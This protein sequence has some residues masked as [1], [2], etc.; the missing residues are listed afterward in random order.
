[1]NVQGR[2]FFVR[3]S[4]FPRRP[5]IF[6]VMN[7]RRVSLE[8]GMSHGRFVWYDLSTPDPE[9][10]EA[11]YTN[12]I[13][14]GT[15]PIPGPDGPYTLFMV[16]ETPVCG[17]M[18][19]PEEAKKLSAPPHWMG[20]VVVDNVDA[21]TAAAQQLGATIYIE[22]R[23][24]TDICRFSVIADP[25][26]AAIGMMAWSA[27]PEAAGAGTGLPAVPGRIG[28]HELLTSD[29]EQGYCFYQTLFGWQKADALDA[30]DIGTYQVF[31][32]GGHLAGGMFNKPAEI[33]ATFWLYYFN[34]ADFDAAVDRV[35]TFGGDVVT[36]PMEVP[37]GSWIIHARDPQGALFALV[38]Q[39]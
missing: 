6:M 29:W 34:V 12:V 37:G 24:I 15:L 28:W 33:P 1:M 16:G 23:D 11:Y 22:P 25:Q 10:A 9:A 14:W 26:K 8:H 38:G 39:R 13:G 35:R 21:S 19:L 30:G 4:I 7:A 2:Q 5:R 36:G 20:Y 17:L 18:K 27:P 31:A 32:T 3:H